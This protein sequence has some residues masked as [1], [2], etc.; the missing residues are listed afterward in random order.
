MQ[1]SGNR[2]RLRILLFIRLRGIYKR[3]SNRIRKFTQRILEEIR[4]KLKNCESK[5]EIA[6]NLGVPE[7]TLRNQL[8]QGTIP[9]SLGRFKTTFTSKMERELAQHIRDLDIRFYGIAL[10]NLLLTNSRWGTFLKICDL[11]VK[12]VECAILHSAMRDLIQ[13]VL[14]DGASYFLH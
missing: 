7:S 6:R 11:S 5:R 4:E 9:T 1:K 2:T 13:L 12:I 14:Q 3:K 10:N 8:K